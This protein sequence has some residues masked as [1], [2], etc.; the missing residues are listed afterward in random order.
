LNSP[1]Q[2]FQLGSSDLTSSSDAH[3]SPVGSLLDLKAENLILIAFKSSDTAAQ[4]W[5]LRCYECHGVTGEIDL[6]GELGLEIDRVV[7]LFDEPQSEP[8][9]HHIK[10]WQIQS[11]GMSI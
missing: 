6:G 10:P 9:T 5:V 11:F 1:L 2:V 4:P 3:L 7:N 8:L